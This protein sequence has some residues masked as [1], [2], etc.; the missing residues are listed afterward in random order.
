MRHQ[1]MY[2]SDYVENLDRILTST[3]ESLLTDAGKIS[4]TQAI[5]KA[6]AEYKKYQ[7]QT[8]SPVEKDYLQTIRAI[9]SVA[10]EG[11]K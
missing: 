10:K 8:L 3:G 4:H 2:M 9:E 6:N 1:P 5:E 11:S 7:V